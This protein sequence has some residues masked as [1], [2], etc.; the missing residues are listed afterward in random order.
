MH[1]VSSSP[2]SV[3]LTCTQFLGTGKSTLAKAVE[4]RLPYFT[5][6]SIDE[7]LV[8]KHG[9]YGIDYP[10]DPALYDQYQD[11][12][13]HIYLSR[14][15]SLL[16]ERKDIILEKSFYAKEDRDDYRRLVEE[17]GGGEYR[18]VLVF[19][20]PGDKEKLWDRIVSRSQEAKGAENCL[21][22]SRDLF[23]SYWDGFEDP[24]EEG[25][26]VIEVV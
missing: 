1:R 24:V 16:G 21:E 9:L 26:L 8:E 20:H 18:V 13:D 4:V 25:E 19:L 15:K 12:G 7:I 6:L 11:E 22:I 2:R 23:D 10:P 5:R 17:V 14:L 3:A